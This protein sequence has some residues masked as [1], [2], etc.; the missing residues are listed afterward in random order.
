MESQENQIIAR[1]SKGS[2]MDQIYLPKNRQGMMAGEYVVINVLTGP[3]QESEKTKFKPYF[4]GM[5][6]IEP[7]KLELVE[8]ILDIIAKLTEKGDKY[9][10]IIITGSFLESGFN[11]NDIDV[12]ILCDSTNTKAIEQKIRTQIGIKPHLI[13]MTWEEFVQG[14][15]SD[16]LYQTMISRCISKNRLIFN[17]KPAI[18]AKL[19]DLH[20]FKSKALMDNF[21]IL[22]GKEKYYLT[23]NLISIYLFLKYGKI[24]KDIVE[25]TIKSEFNIKTLE[26]IKENLVDEMFLKRYKKIYEKT[27]DLIMNGV[28]HEPK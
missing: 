26:E 11:F 24:T 2:K 9:S 19:L 17:Y 15:A 28:K 22:N 20:L 4:Y 13:V 23:F 21:E 16:P 25:K 3:I 6:Q 10:N 18:N 27:F 1:I 7:I 12:L 8:K 5:K 14:L